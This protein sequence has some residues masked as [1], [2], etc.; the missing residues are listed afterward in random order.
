MS[1]IEQE[2]FSHHISGNNSNRL[3]AILS[4]AKHDRQQGASDRSVS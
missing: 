3:A 1:V 4:S 2:D